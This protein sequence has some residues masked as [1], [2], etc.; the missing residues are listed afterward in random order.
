L[1]DLLKQTRKE[2][3]TVKNSP[4]WHAVMKY[5][6]WLNRHRERKWF[7]FRLYDNF[8]ASVTAKVINSGPPEVDDAKM[9]P[10]A[11][12]TRFTPTVGPVEDWRR[13]FRGLAS[14]A[15]LAP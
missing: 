9:W 5:R 14:H 11:P 15:G 2:L 13:I 3:R 12:A 10:I 4:A 7:S 8:L 1:R 6:E